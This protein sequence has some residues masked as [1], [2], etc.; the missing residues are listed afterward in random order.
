[1]DA[2]FIKGILNS[3]NIHPVAVLNCWIAAIKLFDFNLHH[4]LATQ[5]IA[6]DGLSR[7]LLAPEDPEEVNKVDDWLDNHL[8]SYSLDTI[9]LPQSLSSFLLTTQPDIAHSYTADLA[10]LFPI[11][12]DTCHCDECLALVQCFLTSLEQPSDF[13]ADEFA[14]L[15]REASQFFVKDG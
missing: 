8:D 3:L 10:L 4:I 9:F 13:T 12:N 7:Q 5:I 11:S 6:T 1:M 14:K 15:A 2:S